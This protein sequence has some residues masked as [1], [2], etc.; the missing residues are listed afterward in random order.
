MGCDIVV[1]VG[2][3]YEPER[4]RYDHHQRGF[5]ETMEE[6]RFETKLSS[7]GLVFRHFG[8]DFLRI[9]V[10]EQTPEAFEALYQKVYKSFMHEIDGVDNG[11]EC[12]KGGSRNYEVTTTLSARVQSLNPEWNG[13]RSDAEWNKRFAYALTL[14][15]TE[16]AMA[17]G[18]FARAWWPARSEVKAALTVRLP[19]T[20]LARLWFWT[21]MSPTIRTSTSLRQRAASLARLSMCCTPRRAPG[22]SRPWPS[23]RVLSP[24]G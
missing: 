24:Q 21:V 16:F 14:V 15:G 17:V 19:C 5:S 1:D 6:L 11:D 7:A 23:R 20:S 8:K 10:G 9:A 4:H 13:D 18:T 2:G 3:K 22:A 12:F